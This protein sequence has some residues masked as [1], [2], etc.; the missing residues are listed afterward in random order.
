MADPAHGVVH[1]NLKPHSVWIT[2]SGEV[3][4]GD[5]G[6]SGA[7]APAAANSAYRSCELLAGRSPDPSDDIYS[8]AC[9]AYELLSGE[10]PF[11][12]R[13]STEARNFA[14]VPRRIPDLSRRQ[15]RMLTMGLCWHRAGRSIPVLV[16]AGRLVPRRAAQLPVAPARELAPRP[17]AAPTGGLRVGLAATLA[18]LV[19]AF[20]G[21]VVVRSGVP[22]PAVPAD[23][24]AMHP[25]P[26]VVPAPT[27]PEPA[28]VLAHE[29]GGGRIPAV[30]P[31]RAAL[32]SSDYQILP[33]EHYAEIRIHLR[34]GRS[35]DRALTWWTEAA[36]A[37][38]GIDYVTQEKVTQ[39]LPA[40]RSTASFFVKLVPR[41]MRTRREVF[42]VDI[43]EGP[44][45]SV[46]GHIAR[47][48]VWLPT[49]RNLA[50]GG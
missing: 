11:Q 44:A 25:Q 41:T 24:I 49:N 19:S 3:R 38:P 13:P 21:I 9:L 32:F 31:G 2:Q 39:A 10:H 46:P 33:G 7:G 1:A 26:W 16:W 30:A 45:G 22:L 14:I 18:V 48:A 6:W 20:V 17:S 28:D 12:R 35:R 27:A 29:A 43:A 34:A 23:A 47:A 37:K 5:F 40:G 50:S 4:L 15:W 36:S 42:Y 8:F